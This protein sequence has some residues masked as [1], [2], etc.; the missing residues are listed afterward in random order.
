MRTWIAIRLCSPTNR[1]NMS[2]PTA[3]H[4][5]LPSST[6]VIG[7]TVLVFFFTVVVITFPVLVIGFG[8]DLC[9]G[10]PCRGSK[11]TRPDTLS[12]LHVPCEISSP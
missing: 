6:C 12:P 3:R 11:L 5:K 7:V 9:V 1:R 4:T 8:S 2:C 10:V